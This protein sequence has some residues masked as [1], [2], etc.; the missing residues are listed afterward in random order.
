MKKKT[1]KNYAV[2]LCAFTVTTK[3]EMVVYYNDAMEK[4][5]VDFAINIIVTKL[6][7]DIRKWK[8]YTK[9]KK[10]RISS[11]AKILLIIRSSKTFFHTTATNAK[12]V[13]LGLRL[14]ILKF[15]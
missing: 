6:L 1:K 8:I 11:F 4:A 9:K 2:C 7:F 15:I 13:L 3:I 12:C 5:I 14:L 10:K